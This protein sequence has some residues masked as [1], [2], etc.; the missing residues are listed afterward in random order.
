MTMVPFVKVGQ[1]L[2]GVETTFAM[3]GLQTTSKQSINPS[4]LSSIP[5]PHISEQSLSTNDTGLLVYSS[6]HPII[7]FLT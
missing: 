1:L 6:E 5:L 2:G 3:D 7:I 4:P